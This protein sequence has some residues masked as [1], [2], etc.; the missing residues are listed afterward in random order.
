[1]LV[2]YR[3]GGQLNELP[4]DP[5]RAENDEREDTHDDKSKNAGRALGYAE[6]FSACRCCHGKFPGRRLSLEDIKP[7]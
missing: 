4:I 1:L 7:I 3:A 5:M 2:A 6:L